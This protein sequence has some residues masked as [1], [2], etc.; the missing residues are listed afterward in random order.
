MISSRIL[1]MDA[2]GVLPPGLPAAW[3]NDSKGEIVAQVTTSVEEAIEEITRQGFDAVI[4]WAEHR[5][6]LIGVIRIR[7]GRPSLPIVVLSSQKGA[8][9]RALALQ[10]GA[11]RVLPHSPDLSGVL[12]TLRLAQLSG[13]LAHEVQDRAAE[14]F[15]RIQELQLLAQENRTLARAAYA[16]VRPKSDER[17]A[18]LLVEDNPNHAL[19]MLRAFEKAGV[20]APLPVMRSGEE[21][22]AYLSAL[23][24]LSQVDPSLPSIVILD[25]DLPRMSGLDVLEWMRNTRTVARLPAVI[26]SSSTNPDHVNRAYQLGA[27]SYLLKPTSFESLVELV[28]MLAKNRIPAPRRNL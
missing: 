6:D 21:A 26:L 10:M 20:V 24:P 23:A 19:L 5:D 7:K 4:C 27:H 3:E 8:G 17:F 15:V 9:F 13:E 14:N 1:L 2:K 11:T 22:V 16:Q 12:Q 18:P 28:A 25:L